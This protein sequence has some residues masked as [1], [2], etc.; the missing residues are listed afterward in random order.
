[1]TVIPVE[2]LSLMTMPMARDVLTC[3]LSFDDICAMLRSHGIARVDLLDLEVR[4]YGRKRVTRALA[5]NNISVS[6]L[7]ASVPLLTGSERAVDRRVRSII[8]CAIDLGA[9]RI[10][11]VPGDL[12]TAQRRVRGMPA[13]DK[14]ARYARSLARAV[15]LAR[16]QHLDVLFEDT[17][18]LNSGL[19]NSAECGAVLDE[20]S[21]LG[22]VFD[23]ANM[24][25][26]GEAP[27]DFYEHLKSHVSYVQFKDV[28]VT[29]GTKG[30]LMH[31]GRR[32]R[33]CVWGEGI[34]PLQRL[35]DRLES[36][37][38]HGVISIEYCAPQGRGTRQ[39]HERQLG[40]FLSHEIAGVPA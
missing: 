2:R 18:S 13:L 32:I 28:R 7:I 9:P 37:G 38:Y 30:D 4:L 14:Q 5:R 20:V 15:D 8:S 36:D 29:E 35:A 19:S 23:T 39:A 27:I 3:R 16:E 25:I 6:S 10:M 26:S 21:G 17:P 12:V 24:I 1:M 22:L 40:L 33:T 11:V 34:V 31:D